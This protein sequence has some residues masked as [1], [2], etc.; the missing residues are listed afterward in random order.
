MGSV[1]PDR[2]HFRRDLLA[3]LPARIS[4]QASSSASQPDGVAQAASLV[5]PLLTPSGVSR[6]QFL[7][8]AQAASLPFFPAYA[9]SQ[10]GVVLD[11]VLGTL[12]GDSWWATLTGRMRAQRVLAHRRTR[13]WRQALQDPASYALACH[14]SARLQDGALLIRGRLTYDALLQPPSPA[15]PTLPAVAEADDASAA[16]HQQHRSGASSWREQLRT[17]G[18]RTSGAALLRRKLGSSSELR[19]EVGAQVPV[20]HLPG[21]VD[22]AA[23]GSGV[24]LPF[25]ASVDVCTAPNVA[26][27]LQYRV[28]LQHAVVREG[29]AVLGARP[30]SCPSC[31]DAVGGHMACSRRLPL[32]ALLGAEGAAAPTR[33]CALAWPSK[34]RCAQRDE[35]CGDTLAAIPPPPSIMHA[36]C[37]RPHL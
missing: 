12:G 30:Q 5:L 23:R 7:V 34:V 2:E 9:E 24:Q 31:L 20:A 27:A 25:L 13:G 4:L 36:A 3:V 16:T 1:V 14:S 19:A 26:R 6:P 28:G 11:R 37:L 15:R 22:G 29:G 21:G 8:A 32:R 18:R 35:R 33:T 10:G 17:H